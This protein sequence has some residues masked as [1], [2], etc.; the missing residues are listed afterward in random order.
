MT[1]LIHVLLGI[2][3]RVVEI[4]P[5]ECQSGAFVNITA[6]WWSTNNHHG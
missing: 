3:A 6:Y 2:V 5:V 4:L 1:T